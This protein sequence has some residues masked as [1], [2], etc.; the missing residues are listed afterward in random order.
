[1]KRIIVGAMALALATVLGACG[2][3]NSENAVNYHSQP[4]VAPQSCIRALDEAEAIVHGPVIESSRDAQVLAS[5]ITKAYE[6]GSTGNQG[7]TTEV[8]YTL[9]HLTAR[10]KARTARLKTMV[11]QYNTD[12]AACRNASAKNS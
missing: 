7:E 11:N 2:D 1:M 5:L 12:A 3:D 10:T 6:A 9:K 8:I 4:V